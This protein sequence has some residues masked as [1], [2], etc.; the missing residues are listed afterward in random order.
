MF[1]MIT[2]KLNALVKHVGEARNNKSG[3]DP[4][5]EIEEYSKEVDALSK[6]I[7]SLPS[8]Y[9]AVDAEEKHKVVLYIND[10]TQRLSALMPSPGG[11][12][13]Y[14]TQMRTHK[15]TLV[16]VQ[17]SQDSLHSIF[18]LSYLA[19][20]Q[21]QFKSLEQHVK[22]VLLDEQDLVEQDL[23]E[24]K[25]KDVHLKN[26]LNLIIQLIDDKKNYQDKCEEYEE[27]VET[28][29]GVLKDIISVLEPVARLVPESCPGKE[30][31]QRTYLGGGGGVGVGGGTPKKNSLSSMLSGMLF[32]S[33]PKS[34]GKK[35]A[36]PAEPAASGQ[37]GS[38]S[39]Q[40]A[41]DADLSLTRVAKRR[42]MWSPN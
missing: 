17:E 29:T 39:A 20:K 14:N 24:Q 6:V 1:K 9:P 10:A 40:S 31:P 35:R 33:T 27:K 42:R 11:G 41:S 30:P 28:T 26:S 8:H 13:T 34:K 4:V 3:G 16:Q 22:N 32:K 38:S 5:P 18:S 25:A 21:M 36:A 7:E 15:R 23:V 12:K 37:S 19:V 2:K